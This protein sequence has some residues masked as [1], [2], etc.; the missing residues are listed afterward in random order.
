[1]E[2]LGD[3]IFLT[4]VINA[5]TIIFWGLVIVALPIAFLIGCIASML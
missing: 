2:H 1:M 4:V 3:D 5:L